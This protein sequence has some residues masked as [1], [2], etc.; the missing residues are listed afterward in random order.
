MMIASTIL[1]ELPEN[2]PYASFAGGCFWCIESEFRRL[3]GVLYTRSGYEGGNTEN[4]TYEQIGTG[5]TGHAETTEIY[6]DPEKI[7]YAE[8]LEHFLT[9]AHDPT[10]LNGQGVDRG[11]QYRSAIF[12][13]DPAQ[14]E[15]AE[16]MIEAVNNQKYWKKPIVTEVVPHTKFWPAEGYHQQYYEKYEGKTG[17]PHIRALYKLQKWARQKVGQK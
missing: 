11:T 14:K 8:L 16:R 10:D 13:H 4:P 12:Y 7:S 1:P 17:V 15:Q 5:R 3:E 2:A 6:Y 9:L